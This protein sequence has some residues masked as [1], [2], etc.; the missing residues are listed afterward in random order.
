MTSISLTANCEVIQALV[1]PTR[2]SPVAICN[3]P[4]DSPQQVNVTTRIRIQNS[5]RRK[6]SKKSR[7]KTRYQRDVF[8]R[9]VFRVR[10]GAF[11]SVALRKTSP[12]A[13][14][15]ES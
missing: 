5:G 7:L 12:A 4:V 15:V 13:G 9:A 8:I 6:Q 10:R 11:P 14:V 1:P 3:D 2:L